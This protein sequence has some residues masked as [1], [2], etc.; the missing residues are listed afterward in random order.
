MRTHSIR[1]HPY[2]CR[3]DKENVGNLGRMTDGE[4][5]VLEEKHSTKSIR[6]L[7]GSEYTESLY[8]SRRF[9]RKGKKKR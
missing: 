4:M 7:S 8:K 6:R 5:A 9:Q 2:G 1:N 3:R